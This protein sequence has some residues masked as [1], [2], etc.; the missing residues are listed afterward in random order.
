MASPVSSTANPQERLILWLLATMQC[1][2]VLDFVIMMPLGPQFMRVFHISPTQ[3]GLLVS[4]YAIS[5]GIAGII[6]ALC[7]DR[8][9]RKPA[10]MTLYAGFGS[11]TLVCALAPGFYTLLV[12]RVLAGA[13]GGV[14]GAAVLAAVGDVVPDY[15]RGAA[16]GMVMSS[17]SVA[18]VAGVPFGLFLANHLGWHAPFFLLVGMC[19]IVLGVVGRTFPSLR[20]HLGHHES[21]HPLQLLIEVLTKPSHLRSF[22]LTAMICLA[23]FTVIPFLSPYLVKN[24]GLREA[25]LPLIYIFGGGFTVFTMNAIGRLADRLGR[26]RVFTVMA[27]LAGMVTLALTHLPRLHLALIL[28]VTTLFMICMSGRFVPAMALITASIEPR[29]RGGFMS[30]NSSVQSVFAGVGSFVSGLIINESRTGELVGYGAVGWLSVIL[31]AMCIPVAALLRQR[32]NNS[33]SAPEATGLAA[34][35]E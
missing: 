31:M 17:F 33:A 3:F 29:Y 19:V 22:S 13:F 25:E 32:A 23:G 28:T 8:F 20:G 1:T 24:A 35:R 11:G 27:T 18:S 2:N 12:G 4:A 10:L 9:D 34:A 5:A 14:T 6:A 26:M 15:R 16:M 21:Q 30:V 7:L